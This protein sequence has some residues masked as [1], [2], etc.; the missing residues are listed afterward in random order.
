MSR[1]AKTNSP[2]LSLL[3]LLLVDVSSRAQGNEP[4][5]QADV[6]D[7]LYKAY[8]QCDDKF[9]QSRSEFITDKL[10]R[11]GG[12]GMSI[13]LLRKVLTHNV[14]TANQSIADKTQERELY[15]EQILRA[16]EE[17]SEQPVD[18]AEKPEDR[19][20]EIRQIDDLLKEKRQYVEIHEC[21]LGVL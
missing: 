12:N 8:V 2:A 4:L 5:I 21:V 17:P 13:D 6:Y 9:D 19:H 16:D 3:V 18:S 11:D 20:K 14:Q 15:V 1:Y 7:A 10:E